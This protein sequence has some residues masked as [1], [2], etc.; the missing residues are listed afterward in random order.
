MVQQK[1]VD[2]ITE[3]QQVQLLSLFLFGKFL[4]IV[5]TVTAVYVKKY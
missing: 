2:L 4:P 3:N 1:F 5:F